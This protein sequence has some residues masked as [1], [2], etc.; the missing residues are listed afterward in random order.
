MKPDYLVTILS[1]STQTDP[2][3]VLQ[4]PPQKPTLSQASAAQQIAVGE[5]V[6]IARRVDSLENAMERLRGLFPLQIAPMNTLNS[7]KWEIGR[8]PLSV[9]V[10]L[11]GPDDVVAC[12]YDIDL[13]GYGDSIP[14][15]LDDLRTVIIG[16]FEY[17]LDRQEEIKLG[18]APKQQLEYLTRLLVKKDA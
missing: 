8:P 2:W 6:D 15:A 10:E 3:S 4:A 1:G 17:L 18:R 14:E 5:Y 16:Q 11:R 12:L 13:Y 7:S 9:A